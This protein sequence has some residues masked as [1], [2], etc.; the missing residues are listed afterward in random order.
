MFLE[1]TNYSCVYNEPEMY[2]ACMINNLLSPI[3]LTAVV[4]IIFEI[5]LLFTAMH[6]GAF[7]IL[8]IKKKVI[9]TNFSLQ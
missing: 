5:M 2:C 8:C 3:A 1:W 4:G 6:D 9:I 7:C